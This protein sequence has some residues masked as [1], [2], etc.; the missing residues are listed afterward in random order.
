M[1]ET[2]KPNRMDI[3]FK[4]E[5]PEY[6]LEVKIVPIHFIS[7]NKLNTMPLNNIE[8]L[9]AS[10]LSH[11]LQEKIIVRPVSNR[12][13]LEVGNS[14]LVISGHRRL[15][16]LQE[17]NAETGKY[18]KLEV[19]VDHRI[20]NEIDER[21]AIALGNAQR[22][23]DLEVRYAKTKEWGLI[24]DKMH[25][26]GMI[27]KDTAVAKSDWIGQRMNRSGRT[28]RRYWKEM[29]LKDSG[30]AKKDEEDIIKDKEIKKERKKVNNHSKLKKNIVSFEQVICDKETIEMI[31]ED[32]ELLTNLK[33]LR[34]NIESVL[35]KVEKK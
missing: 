13:Y 14:Y 10:I 15:Q 11:G 31:Q 35:L 4:Q 16:A 21:I 17:I 20:E 1:S 23:E 34:S 28:I 9:K 7:P 8:D 32:E 18:Q 22:E 3:F 33:S 6:D 24:F 30:R 27:E 26:Q 19:F 29:G 2:R 12:E 5:I 25:K